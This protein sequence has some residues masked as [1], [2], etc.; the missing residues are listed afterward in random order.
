M[1]HCAFNSRDIYRVVR[2]TLLDI[3]IIIRIIRI[4]VFRIILV[5]AFLPLLSRSAMTINTCKEES[6]VAQQTYLYTR[7]ISHRTISRQDDIGIL[8]G[9]PRF[10]LVGPVIDQHVEQAR[11]GLALD[12]RLPS[13]SS[14]ISLTN[15][16]RQVTY[17][18]R[19]ARGAMI[20]VVL[21]ALS[22]L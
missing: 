2:L 10:R 17:W 11:G 19:T 16:S 1:K 8:E 5:S 13:I 4:L 14:A 6:N 12:F 15:I 18:V 22:W 7:L 21:Q 9:I 3:V 20:K